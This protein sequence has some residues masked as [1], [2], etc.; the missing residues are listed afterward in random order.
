M[1]GSRCAAEG[2]G[3]AGRGWRR[4]SRF[5][6]LRRVGRSLGAAIV[7]AAAAA[8]AAVR[9]A[10]V[11]LAP[12]ATRD[13][14]WRSPRSGTGSTASRGTARRTRFADVTNPATGAV[15][16]AGRARVGRR[17]R[18]RRAQRAG[19]RRRLA[20]G[21]AQPPGPRAVRVPRAARSSARTTSRARITA[22]HGKVL[23]DAL[24]EVDARHR[25]RRVRVRHPA[26]ARR[27]TTPSRCR[28]TPTAY[29]IRQPLGVVAG[30]TP[31]NFP[32]MVP[33]WMFPLAIACGNAFVLKPS[34]RDPSASMLVAELW[35]DAGLPDGVFNVVHGDREAV[36]ALLAHPDV[37]AISFVGSTPV[38]RHVYATAADERQARAGARRREEPH[39]RAARRRPRHRGR[40]RGERGLRLGGRALHG[41]LGGRRGR[42]DRRRARRA[43]RRA[44]RRPAHRRRHR[45]RRRHGPA[46][47][48]GAPRS[49][50]GARRRRRGRGRGAR[51]RRPR[52]SRSTG[53]PTA[54]GSGPCLFDHVD[55]DMAI[56][57]EEIF[58]PVLERR[59]GRLLRGG[60][61]RS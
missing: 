48:R 58:G 60:A 22:E 56:Y 53:D 44:H 7:A 19:G 15:T 5:S 59:A 35:R 45:A 11:T 36:D 37:A 23:G 13:A 39:D 14:R 6:S 52:R 31:F 10:L 33:M 18:H 25:G 42:P 57:R 55:T 47:H 24:G 61:S 40:R 51:R 32:A 27:A 21:V 8:T 1:H 20:L 34:E 28:P 9:V 16:G 41:D 2:A 26:P 54:S 49:R 50:R 29:S 3:P 17:R 4:R 46:R 30:I 38:A 12:R 43:H